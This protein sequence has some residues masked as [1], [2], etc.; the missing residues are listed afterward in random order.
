MIDEFNRT[1]KVSHI[2]KEIAEID[3]RM[4]LNALLDALAVPECYQFFRFHTTRLNPSNVHQFIF[5]TFN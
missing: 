4:Y 2:P 1:T 5:Q 3:N